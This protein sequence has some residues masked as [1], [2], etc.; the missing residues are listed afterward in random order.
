MKRPAKY[1]RAGTGA[2]LTDQQGRVLVFERRD[3][4][5]AWQFPQGGIEDKEDPIDTVLREIREETG[6]SR[7]ALTLL[8]RYPFSCTSSRGRRNQ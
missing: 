7:K 2:V 1:F 5:G 8:D 3:V 6:I 4:P